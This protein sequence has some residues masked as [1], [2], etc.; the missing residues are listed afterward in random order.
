[1][2]MRYH[3]HMNGIANLPDFLTEWLQGEILLACHRVGLYHGL[4]FGDTCPDLS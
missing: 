2:G 3:A 1:M 4:T